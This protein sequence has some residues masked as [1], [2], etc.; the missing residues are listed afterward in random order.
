MVRAASV[1]GRKVAHDLLVAAS[2]LEAAEL[3][4]GLRQAVEMN[5]LVA[6]D[7]TYSFRHAL[8]GEA[9]YDDLLPGSGCGCTRSTPRRCSEGRAAAPPPSWRGTPGWPTT[10]TPR[11]T[12]ASA[13]ATR[14]WRWPAPTRRRTTTSRPSSCSPTRPGAPTCDVDVS[15]LAVSA[16]EA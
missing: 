10:S 6:G 1:A 13:P 7:G 3:D 11:L 5:V 16:A 12:P 8:L 15:K 14:R 4:H 2:G 9:V